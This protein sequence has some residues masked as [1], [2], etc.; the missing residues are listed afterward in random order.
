MS[1]GDSLG[2]RSQARGEEWFLVAEPFL[3]IP[4]RLAENLEPLTVSSEN[5]DVLWMS[6]SQSERPAAVHS[7]YCTIQLQIL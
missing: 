1:V 4:N 6:G 7:G 5:A 3:Q 2:S